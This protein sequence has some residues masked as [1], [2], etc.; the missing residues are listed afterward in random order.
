MDEQNPK[1]ETEVSKQMDELSHVISKMGDNIEKLKA[2]LTPILRVDATCESTTNADKVKIP[3]VPLAESILV[4]SDRVQ[5][6]NTV[7]YDIIET[8]EL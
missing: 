3:L 6:Y 5:L 7:F 4:L 1:K 2:K 8:C